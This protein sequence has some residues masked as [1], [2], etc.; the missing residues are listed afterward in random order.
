LVSID[1]LG[2]SAAVKHLDLQN[3]NSPLAGKPIF[4]LVSEAD[5]SV[6]AQL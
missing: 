1:L 6:E 4:G 5:H 3:N 2:I